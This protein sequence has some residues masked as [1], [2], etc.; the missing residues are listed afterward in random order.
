M[1]ILPSLLPQFELVVKTLT[2]LNPF[3]GII[4]VVGVILHKAAS[5][6]STANGPPPIL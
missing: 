1:V 6:T 4:V 2:I 3:G 5:V